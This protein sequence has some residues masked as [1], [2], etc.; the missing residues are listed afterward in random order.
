MVVVVSSEVLH[1]DGDRKR[2][3]QDLCTAATSI[4]N[5]KRCKKVFMVLTG[6]DL[7]IEC[8][9][10]DPGDGAGDPD[11]LAGDRAGAEV[12]VPNTRQRLHRQVV[13]FQ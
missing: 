2:Q 3:H 6:P 13:T 12:P 10:C 8:G 9:A 11:Q 4:K 1:H 5:W 7:S